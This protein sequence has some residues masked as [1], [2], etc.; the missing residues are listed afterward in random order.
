MTELFDTHCH[1]DMSH[2]KD[3]LPSVIEKARE[4]GVKY[5]LTVGTDIKKKKKAIEIANRFE[6]VYASVGLHPHDAKDMN[7]RTIE[8][9]KQLAKEP[10]VVAVGETGLDYH[11]NHSPREIQ[12]EAFRAQI[13]LAIQLNLPLIVHSRK[14]KEDTLGILN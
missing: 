7:D 2:F 6:G 12:K 3:D 5:I 13:E 11:Y 4:A 8:Q 9:L 14:A 1:L 10:K